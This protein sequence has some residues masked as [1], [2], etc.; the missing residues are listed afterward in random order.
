MWRAARQGRP[1]RAASGGWDG[2]GGGR[3]RGVETG[4]EARTMRLAT[5]RAPSK[6]RAG[7]AVSAAAARPLRRR[8]L[9]RD[10]SEDARRAAR[11]RC[12]A[13]PCPASPCRGGLQHQGRVASAHRGRA[14]VQAIGGRR[15][16]ARGGGARQ[17]TE[18]GGVDWFAWGARPRGGAKGLGAHA[19]A[20]GRGR[21][22]R[23]AARGARAAGGL[24]QS[25]G[26]RAPP[27]RG[28]GGGQRRGWV[29]GGRDAR[30]GAARRPRQARGPARR[31][32]ARRGAACCAGGRVL[33]AGHGPFWGGGKKHSR[34]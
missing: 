7:C 31:G 17:A 28:V 12:P 27:G 20:P 22:G 34:A 9:T 8:R 24:A 25:V 29:F 21:R 13:S 16:V 33:G 23:P 30:R 32:A 26:L 1:G 11:C 2:G 15:A 14:A 3:E 19:R 5:P 4:R 10:G 6:R 18:R